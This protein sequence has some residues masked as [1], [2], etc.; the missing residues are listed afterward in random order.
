MRNYDVI[1][2]GGGPA[3][4]TLGQYLKERGID[5]L[6]IERGTSYRDKVCAGGV[7]VGITDVLP[8]SKRSFKRVEYNTLS[9]DFKGILKSTVAIN[10][11]FMYGVERAEFDHFLRKGLNIHYNEKFIVFEEEKNGVLV[12]TNKATYNTKFLVGA[13]GVGSRVSILSGLAKKRRFILAEEKETPLKNGDEAN[14]AKIFLGYNRLGYG[15]IFPKKDHYSVGSG[16]LQ[17][18]FLRSKGTVNKFDR[19]KGQTK[20]Y[21]ISL[22]GGEEV[23]TNRRIALVGEAGNLVDPFTAGGIYPAVLSGKLLA[24]SIENALKREQSDLYEYNKLL[25]NEMYEEFHYALF[26]SKMFYPFI[27]LIKKVILSKNV[28]QQAMEFASNG[29]TSYKKFF[30]KVRKTRKAPVKVA[31]FLVKMFA[32]K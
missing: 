22:W 2:I 30:R 8:D 3:G 23:L 17:K 15:W 9:I 32:N 12:R 20:V 18:Y 31:Y 11:P 1:I 24:Q 6:L 4:A 14:R 10:K 5:C 13:D 16:A 7:P 25:M 21:P 28:M 19:S 26:L 27:S 29:Y